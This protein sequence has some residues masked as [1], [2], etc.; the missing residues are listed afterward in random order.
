[1][2]CRNRGGNGGD[3]LFET[4]FNVNK[5]I[6]NTIDKIDRCN[7]KE[8]KRTKIY[9]DW[10]EEKSNF[11]EKE[12]F[13][14]YI[15][16]TVF[17]NKITKF[18]YDKNKE[19]MQL[20]ID[21]YYKVSSDESYYYKKDGFNV[22]ENDKLVMLENLVLIRGNVVWVEFGF[23]VGCEF[24]GKHPAIILKNIGQA[25]IVAPLTSGKPEKPRNSEVIIDMV[26][27]L[28]K[29]NRYTNVTRI[30]PV[31]IYRIDFSSPVGSVKS[32]YM[33]EIFRVMKNEWSF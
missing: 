11:F 27:N 25:L 16:N 31:S 23:N 9:L 12:R 2:Y 14:L 24:G 22:E 5:S 1:M 8:I 33:K 20:L 21:K 15:P 26:Y 19:S 30:T 17:P 4:Y 13:P 18:A 6:L 28:P 29:R 10:L 3:N 32:S 7:N